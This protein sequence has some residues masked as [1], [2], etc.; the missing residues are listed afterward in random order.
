M[1]SSDLLGG[2]SRV[3]VSVKFNLRTFRTFTTVPISSISS[4]MTVLIS[5]DFIS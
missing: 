1:I 2:F 5:Y 4:L 3:S